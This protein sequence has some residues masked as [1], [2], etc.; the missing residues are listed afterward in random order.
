MEKMQDDRL[1][2]SIPIIALNISDL[3]IPV[4]RQRLA[5]WIKLTHSK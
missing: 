4:K 3:N 1:Q 5:D 2:G